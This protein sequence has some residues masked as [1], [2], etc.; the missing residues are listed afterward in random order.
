[1]IKIEYDKL[2]QI[3]QINLPELLQSKGIA[4]KH[5]GNASYIGLC[6]FHK[7]TNPSLHISFKNN[8]W[9]WHCFGCGKSGNAI[10]FIQQLEQKPFKDTYRG[11]VELCNTKKED[12]SIRGILK[13]VIKIYHNSL[14]NSK[15]SQVYLE[16]RGLLDKELIDTFKIGF[17]SGSIKELLGS[18]IKM[19]ELLKE[20]GIL[21]QKYN[22]IYYNCITIPIF[23][24]DE[25][26]G[27]Y[28]RRIN[29]F[30]PKHLYLKGEHKG[31]FNYKAVKTHDSIILTEA[32]IDAL[33]LYRYGF[34]NVISS[35]GTEGFTDIH[36]KLLRENN[37][38]EVSICYDNDS[39]GNLASQKLARLLSNYD[40]VS[41][42]IHLPEGIKDINQ[43]FN[44]NKELDFKGTKDT[45]LY[46]LEKAKKIGYR[47][48]ISPE[49]QHLISQKDLDFIFLYDKI[50]YHVHLID[51]DTAS[52]LRTLITAKKDHK[53]HIDKIDLYSQ[54]ARAIFSNI[55]SEKFSIPKTSTENPLLDMIDILEAFKERFTNVPDRPKYIIKDEDKEVA[56]TY[57]KDP[58]LIKNI[59]KDIENIGCIGETSNKLIA[60]LVASSRKLQRPLSSI[61]VSQSATGKSFLMEKIASLMPDEEVEFYSRITPQSLYYMEKDQLKHKLL[62]VD[63]RSGS[64][65]AD[66]AIR[67]LQTRHKLSLAYPLKDPVDGKLKTIVVEMS[68][69]IAFMESSTKAKLN[70]ENTTRSFMLY[71]D[72]SEGQTKCIQQYQR[73]IRTL[74]GKKT[75]QAIPHIINLHKN[76]QRLLKPIDVIIDFK[77]L[78]FPTTW[79]RTRRDQERFLSLIE[80][81]THLHQYQRKIEKDPNTGTEYIKS[82]QKDYEIAYNLSKIALLDTLNDLPRPTKAF[83]NILEEAVSKKAVTSQK[84]REDFTFR[85]R[86]IREWLSLPDHVVKRH[87]RLLEEL[88]YVNVK[89]DTKNGYM[90]YTL[91]PHN[92][93]SIYLEGLTEPESIN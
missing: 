74:E 39:T 15:A 8:K 53:K 86:D 54:K 62:V 69:P 72:E 18:D 4:L 1:M 77:N 16:R 33:T 61:I 52:S 37:V 60:Y 49:K 29:D 73:Y 76:I 10:D 25:I 11:L 20:V 83:Y 75:Q 85:R 13:D 32:I 68:G 48:S 34:K 79:I 90:S 38:K 70:I 67:S 71:L 47:A 59:L 58:D 9:I 6:P 3:K 23:D 92:R 82:T 55:V 56:L 27:L 88:E 2:T 12:I 19:K 35:Y 57:L 31:V 40:I 91:L 36:L 24:E 65:E 93:E 80:V 7:D 66:Y 87:M 50:E 30:E 89:R 5:T 63:E 41:K 84:D 81:I 28:G 46:L 43:Y 78:S 21:N 22:E 45:F 51:V 42:R 17:C 26:V 64:E 44:Y 14:M